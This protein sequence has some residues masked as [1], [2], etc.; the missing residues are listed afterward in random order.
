MRRHSPSWE[1]QAG[2]Q[3]YISAAEHH[4][5]LLTSIAVV[6]GHNGLDG[7]NVTIGDTFHQVGR[8]ARDRT[9][10]VFKFQVLMCLRKHVQYL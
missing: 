9:T 7:A 5:T 2:V 8:A 1:C 6:G 3:T 4:N 10:Q